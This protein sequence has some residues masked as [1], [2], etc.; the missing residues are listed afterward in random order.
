MEIYRFKFYGFSVYS[1]KKGNFKTYLL[2][3][4]VVQSF[5]KQPTF[6]VTC[7]LHML[8]RKLATQARKQAS[9]PSASPWSLAWLI[10]GPENGGD[11]TEHHVL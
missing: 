11:I 3:Y 2:G 1:E 7:S 5:E 4:T 10:C 8:G 9:F 6:R